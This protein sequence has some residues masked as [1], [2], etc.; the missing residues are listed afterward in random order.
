MLGGREVGNIQ[1]DLFFSVS[2][3]SFLPSFLPLHLIPSLSCPFTPPFPFTSVPFSIILLIFSYGFFPISL[4]KHFLQV[5]FFKKKTPQHSLLRMN[6]ARHQSNVSLF[7][8]SFFS[9]RIFN[10]FFFKKKKKVL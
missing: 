9:L 3:L 5:F 7:L 4:I 8:F 1:H 10:P 6:R 2:L